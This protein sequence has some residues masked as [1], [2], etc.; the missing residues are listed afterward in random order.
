MARIKG[1]IPGK[2]ISPRTIEVVDA[3]GSKLIPGQKVLIYRTTGRD[4]VSASGR[5]I[6]KKEKV[7]G[8]GEVRIVGG[9]LI[10]EPAKMARAAP[11]YRYGVKGAISDGAGSKRR[12]AARGA[13]VGRE[14]IRRAASNGMVLIKPI[15]E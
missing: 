14:Y 1:P 5:V 7:F 12:A 8:A 4:I 3:E 2:V 11:A 10:V 9:K 13:M 6:G 15:D